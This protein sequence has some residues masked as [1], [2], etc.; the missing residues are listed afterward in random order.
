MTTPRAHRLLVPL[1]I[2]LATLL[3][4]EWRVAPDGKLHAYFL[5]IGQGDGIF[6]R[7]PQG[8]QV[9][10]DGGPDA[11][12]LEEMG[13]QMSFFDRTIDIIVLSHP[14]L[15]HLSG[16][17]DVMK[18]YDVSM[19]LLPD[20]PSD[21]PRFQEFLALIQEKNIP[22]L[23][24]DAKKDLDLGGGFYLDVLWA[25][26]PATGTSDAN[27]SCAIVKARFANDSVLFTGDITEKEE[28]A[29]LA[30]GADVR[31]T[32]LKIA[33]HGSRFATSTGFL[34]AVTPQT[35]VISAGENTFG[36]PHST[37][38]RR[39]ENFGVSLRSTREEGTV[40]EVVWGW[41]TEGGKGR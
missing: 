14:H 5:D 38:L 8:Q 22:V 33:H 13:K 1:L 40:E 19:I 21:I 20:T 36:H 35:A 25:P 16:L 24:A 3:V 29:I 2:L 26:G 34:L 4:R 30:A 31:S 28:N 10:I 6:L 39:L 17:V 18:R 11:S 41:G 12:V 9:L 23:L 7:G 32:V 37:I 15:D 27:E